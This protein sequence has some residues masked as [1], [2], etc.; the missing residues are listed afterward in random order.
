M[1][2]NTNKQH[3]DKMGIEYG[4]VWVNNPKKYMHFKE[5]EFVNSFLSRENTKKILDIGVGNGRILENYLKNMESGEIEIYGIDISNEMIRICKEEFGKNKKIK[6]IAVCNFSEENIPFDSKFDFISAIRV[7]KYNKNWKE[8]VKKIGD[9]LNDEGVAIFTMPN[10]FSLNIFGRY[11]IPFYRTS[12]KEIIKICREN[13]LKLMDIQ[14]FTRIPDVF[15]NL[16]NNKI[17]SGF[18]ISLEKLLSK[19]FGKIFLGRILFIAVKK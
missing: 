3:W 16:S 7:L 12:K 2:N 1:E 14:S 8:M 17:Y 5:M 19:L 9:L 15:Y 18:I 11:S 10:K 6:K 4:N 13:N